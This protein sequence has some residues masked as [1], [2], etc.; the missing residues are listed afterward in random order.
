[1][2]METWINCRRGKKLFQCYQIFWTAQTTSLNDT[3]LFYI[4][5]Q[6]SN[7]PHPLDL[8]GQ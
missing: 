8:G 3:I 4:M 2:Q 1:M 6:E 7:P 5:M